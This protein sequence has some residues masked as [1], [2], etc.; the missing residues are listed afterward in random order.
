MVEALIRQDRNPM[1]QPQSILI[2]GASS[3]IGEALATTYAAPG[4]TLWLSGRD[5]ERLATVADV[6]RIK[7]AAVHPKVIDVG[8][9]TAMAAWVREAH[10]TKPLDLVIANAGISG[11]SSG[12][13]AEARAEAAREIFRINWDGVLN[14]LDPAIEAMQSDKRGGQI[15]LMSS[16]AGYRGMASA[17]AYSTSKVAVKAYG[18]ALRPGLAKQGIKLSVICP[19]FVKSRITDQN[20]FKMPFFMQ[21]DEA[22]K[23]IKRGLERNSG[24]I[25]F[26]PPMVFGAW[27]ISTFPQA[28]A[29]WVASRLPEKG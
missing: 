15:A 3:G 5:A 11:G 14:T 17:P 12:A 19:G 22:A 25:A 13:D 2:T 18:E 10:A 27:L 24:I 8:D 1:T 28:L 7:G 4:V 20:D 29:E 9:R 16:L 23:V 26:P 21:A 6:L